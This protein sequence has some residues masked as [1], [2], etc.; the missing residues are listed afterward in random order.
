MAFFA[1]FTKVIDMKYTYHFLLCDSCNKMKYTFVMIAQPLY[2]IFT[3]TLHL[4]GALWYLVKLH[5]NEIAPKEFLTISIKIEE[6]Y[7]NSGKNVW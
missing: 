6:S 5:T 3:M 4:E 7:P 2:S 1:S